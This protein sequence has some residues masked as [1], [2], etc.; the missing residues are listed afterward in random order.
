MFARAPPRPRPRRGAARRARR[1]AAA[2]LRLLQHD[3]ADAALPDSA[4]RRKHGYGD[5][6]CLVVADGPGVA[7]SDPP[8]PK[9]QAILQALRRGGVQAA[10]SRAYPGGDVFILLRCPVARLAAMADDQN[11]PLPLDPFECELRALKGTDKI[12]PLNILHDATATRG[13]TPW[14]KLHG[15]YDTHQDLQ[16]RGGALY[17]AA[18]APYA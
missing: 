2:F 14:E 9:V 10:W 12:A 5:D 7:V 17:F 13:A 4:F 18:Q 15:V 6:A 11:M 3:A 8:G 1:D 16:V